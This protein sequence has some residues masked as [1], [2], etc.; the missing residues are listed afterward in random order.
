MRV[1]IRDFFISYVYGYLLWVE[2]WLDLWFDWFN[3]GII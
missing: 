3:Y 1:I 2:L